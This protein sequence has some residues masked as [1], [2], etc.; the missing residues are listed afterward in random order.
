MILLELYPILLC[1]SCADAYSKTITIKKGKETFIPFTFRVN[2]LIL[3]IYP[4]VDIFTGYVMLTGGIYSYKPTGYVYGDP[5]YYE[6]FVSD[7]SYKLRVLD[8]RNRFLAFASYRVSGGV[9][10]TQRLYVNN[11]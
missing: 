6:V 5:A 2:K 8:K 11:W 1:Y 9:V 10:S 3:F 7:G 4:I